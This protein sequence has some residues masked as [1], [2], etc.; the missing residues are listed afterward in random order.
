[1]TSDRNP[2]GAPGRRRAAVGAVGRRPAS[3]AGRWLGIALLPW[4]CSP[5]RGQEPRPAP[6]VLDFPEAGLDDP[7][8]YRGYRTRFFRDVA[9]NTHQVYMDARA[10]RVVAVWA[11][12]ANESVGFTVRDRAGAPALLDWGE[13]VSLAAAAGDRR[14]MEHVI[15]VHPEELRLGLFFLGTMR[16]ERDIQYQRLHRGPLDAPLRVPELVEMVALLSR[17]APAD[18]A[19][20]L[21]LLGA[22]SIGDL[23]DRLEPRLTLDRG[24]EGWRFRAEQVGFHGRGH[25]SLEVAVDPGAADAALEGRVLVLRRRAGGPLPLRL[26]LTTDAPPLTPLARTDIFEPEFLALLASERS[27]LE[28][29]AGATG[30]GEAARE[31]LRHRRLERQVVGAELLVSREKLMAGLPNFATYFG[32]DAFMS[33]LMMEGTWRPEITEHVLATALRKLDDRGAVSH[34][35]AVGGQAVREAAA[36][37][38]RLVGAYLDA[39]PSDPELLRLAEAELTDIGRAR[40]NY[41]MVDDD[42]QLPVVLARWLA[43][44]RVPDARKRE[45]LQEPAGPGLPDRA[46]LVYRNLRY[47]AARAAAYAADPLPENLVSF[48]REEPARWFPGSWRDS[49]PGYGNGRYAFD[50]N[51]IWVPHALAAAG[52]ILGGLADLGLSGPGTV[53]G[54]A[55]V[56]PS[57]PSRPDQAWLERAADV[58]RGAATHF[59]VAFDRA[60]ARD[61][62]AARV[63]AMPEPYDRH[64]ADR[65]ARKG[66]VTAGL[67]FFAVALDSLA[68]PVAVLNTDPATGLFL[69]DLDDAVGGIPAADVLH[70]ILRPYPVGLF[71]PGLGLLV[72]NDAYAPPPVWSAFDGDPYH[73]PRTVWGREVNLVMLGLARRIL[74]ARDPDG[75]L[76]DPALMPAV[77]RLRAALDQ[78]RAAVDASGLAHN[79]LWSYRVVGETLEPVRFGTSTDV[80]LW[81]V[82]DLALHHVLSRLAAP[83]APALP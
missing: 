78:V 12:S 11:N 33:A 41:R 57:D 8:A 24:P 25:L 39:Y 21:A 17:L 83:V 55:A 14:T 31:L 80:Q 34:E 67:R 6:P 48:P 74:D 27:T 15:L 69:G 65:L 51:A 72:A 1:M 35:E 58:W 68:R 22:A 36:E 82:T 70:P 61:A 59:E 3:R 28:A 62:V 10:G 76:R 40:E 66:G 56:T 71:V 63:A 18:R 77:A 44:S 26:R 45:F 20:H 7:E 60:A 38:V 43:D 75:R 50:V 16:F 4:L 79:E 73:S 64:W 49:G 5:A 53:A 42:F 19:R 29:R 23:R 37:Y 13:P 2:G 47:V 32:R 9:G 54:P 81:N 52:A 30:S 46:A